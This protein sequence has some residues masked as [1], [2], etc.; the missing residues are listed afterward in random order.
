MECGSGWNPIVEDR[1]IT[2]A[3]HKTI[4][5]GVKRCYLKPFTEASAA[6]RGMISYFHI[7]PGA[8]RSCTSARIAPATSA[9]IL[10]TTTRRFATAALSA[11]VCVRRSNDG[12]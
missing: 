4:T 12:L 2:H 3:Q 11:L 7:A 6:R 5:K 1:G 8:A 10:A 9:G